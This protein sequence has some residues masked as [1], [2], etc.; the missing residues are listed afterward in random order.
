MKKRVIFT[1]S[2]QYGDYKIGEKGVVDG[3]VSGGDGVPASCAVV[4]KDNGCF[5][6][7]CIHHIKMCMEGDK[8]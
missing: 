4:V 5:V 8:K 2:S 7:V 1:S 6:F 3:Y